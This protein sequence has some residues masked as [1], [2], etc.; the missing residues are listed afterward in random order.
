M[1][2]RL[3]DAV[4]ALKEWW[5]AGY[6]L[7][8][9]LG[10]QQRRPAGRRHRHQ[11]PHA[12]RPLVALPRLGMVALL[13]RWRRQ[14]C[15]IERRIRRLEGRQ[16]AVTGLSGSAKSIAVGHSHSCAVLVSGVGK[17]QGKH[18]CWLCEYVC[19]D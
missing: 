1:W 15:A 5:C 2:Q 17:D 14:T 4:Q 6:R 19:W 7:A 9:V 18:G 8:Q 11:P 13:G 3:S 16:V 10:V 12:G